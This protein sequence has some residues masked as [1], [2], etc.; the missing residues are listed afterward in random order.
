MSTSSIEHFSTNTNTGKSTNIIGGDF[1]F[2]N[3]DNLNIDESEWESDYSGEHNDN[4]IAIGSNDG[5]FKNGFSNDHELELESVSSN[6]GSVVGGI[7][8]NYDNNENSSDSGSVVGGIIDNYDN[9]ENSSDSGSVVGGIIDN[10]EPNNE[11]SSESDYEN[12]NTAGGNENALNEF[13]NNMK[14]LT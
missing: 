4:N 10:H 5:I 1:D 6:S 14:T 3:G 7:I 9:N 11:N 12:G 8:D 13:L 2:S